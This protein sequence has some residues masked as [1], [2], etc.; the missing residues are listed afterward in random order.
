MLPKYVCGNLRL[1]Y[2]AQEQIFI[3]K[4]L[5]STKIHDANIHTDRRTQSV[6]MYHPPKL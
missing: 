6:H 5:I 2:A 3:K 1:Q 4:K